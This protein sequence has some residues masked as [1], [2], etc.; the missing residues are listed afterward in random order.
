MRFLL[1]FLILL[2]VSFQVQAQANWQKHESPVTADLHNV[3]FASDSVG[4]IVTHNTGDILYT[5]N[6]GESWSVQAEMGSMYFEDIYFLNKKI[7]WITAENGTVF[8]TTNG[9]KHWEKDKIADEKSWIYSVHF[10]DK[11]N[12]IAVGLRE[13]QPITLFMKTTDGGK[14]WK[15]IRDKV[16]AS[17][18]EPTYFFD[19]QKGYVAGLS[20]IIFTSDGGNS[21]QT[22]FRIIQSDSTCREAI[23]GLTFKSSNKGWAVGHCGLILNTKD[24]EN[25]ERQEKFTKNRLRNIAFPSPS[26]GYIVGDSN[27]EPGVL[28]H[29]VNSGNTWETVLRDFPDLHRIT[30]TEN[31]IWL[32][33][34]NGTILSKSR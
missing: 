26:E 13:D 25:W 20:N 11:K 19:N 7:G 12:G 32:V 18:Y 5:K 29:T 2:S 9:G 4:W 10:F 33:G 21:W 15:N 1:I 8:K 24:G 14:N 3:F 30:L 17:F 16:P 31:K 6:G 34:D 22:Q 27:K 23:R 28:Y